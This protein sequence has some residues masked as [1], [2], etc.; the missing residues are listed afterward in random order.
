[1]VKETNT[2]YMVTCTLK[3]NKARRG[4]KG[5]ISVFGLEGRLETM[6]GILSRIV[7]DV[8]KR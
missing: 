5:C 7:T 6:S 2:Y 3:K 1:M 4:E 8:Q